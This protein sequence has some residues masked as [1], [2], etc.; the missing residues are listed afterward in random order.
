MLK[1]QVLLGRLWLQILIIITQTR[2]GKAVSLL[3]PRGKENCLKYHSSPGH[4]HLSMSVRFGVYD[5]E[6]LAHSRHEYKLCSWGGGWDKRHMAL[7][8][9]VYWQFRLKS[10]LQKLSQ[11]PRLDSLGA[12]P[13]YSPL[14]YTLG[15]SPP[16]SMCWKPNPDVDWT[17]RWVFEIFRTRWSHES[18]ALL[19]TSASWK[20]GETSSSTW[21]LSCHMMPSAMSQCTK[22]PS[23]SGPHSGAR[24]LQNC[25]LNKFL[26]FTS[27][28][29]ISAEDGVGQ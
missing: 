22:S 23:Q 5:N 14:Q 7:G 9:K 20:T 8:K 4:R 12:S 6:G 13:L 24:S 10:H 17:Q 19:M 29:A 11:L 27:Y 16:Q 26:F 2:V 21:T 3:P 1:S 28:F 15:T 25:V 18:R